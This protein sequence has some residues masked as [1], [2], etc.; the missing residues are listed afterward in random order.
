MAI[1]GWAPSWNTLSTYLYIIAVLPT[2]EL[3]MV[4]SLTDKLCFLGP[5]AFGAP[6][7][8]YVLEGYSINLIE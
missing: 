8:V 3:P 2:D 5:L 4:I 1:V 6:S 7:S